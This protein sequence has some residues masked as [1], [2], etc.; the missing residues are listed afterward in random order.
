MGK[1]A[2]SPSKRATHGGTTGSGSSSGMVTVGGS[3][4][5]NTED[6]L[7]TERPERVESTVVSREN[8]T[9]LAFAASRTLAFPFAAS[10]Q[11]IRLLHDHCNSSDDPS[12][13]SSALLV[14]VGP[15]GT[16]KSALLSHWA[17]LRRTGGEDN[18]THE[19]IYEHYCGCSFDSVKLSL[20]LFRLMHQLKTTF[21]LRDF[22]LPHEHEEEKL[23]FS[24]VRCLEAAVGRTTSTS[25]TGS[26]PSTKRRK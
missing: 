14:V 4:T 26:G 6:L 3:T 12:G 23:K 9:H 25:R 16:G 20:F 21:A 15:P 13:S 17:A 22:E 8:A 1:A 18:G 10:S 5:P 11:Y 19:F 7:L 2:A 24:L